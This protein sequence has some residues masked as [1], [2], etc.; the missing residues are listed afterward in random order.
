[1]AGWLMAIVVGVVFIVLGLGMFIWGRREEKTYYD[2]LA[3]RG[4]LREF[5][6]RWPIRPQPGSLKIGGRIAIAVGLIMV[7]VGGIFRLVG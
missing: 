3:T 4:D 5:F 1:M 2:S 6:D 7:I